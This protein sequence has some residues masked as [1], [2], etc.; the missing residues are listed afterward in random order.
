MKQSSRLSDVLHV[1]LHLAQTD[2][3]LTSEALATAIDTHPVVLRRLMVGLREAG[4]VASEKGHGGGWKMAAPLEGVTLRD[5]H[6]ALGAPALVSLGFR[7]DQPVCLVA[8]V[9]NAS[10]RAS[11]QEAEAVLLN[12]LDNITLAD[13]S[14][15][16]GPR[17]KAHLLSAAPTP[18]PHRLEDHFGQD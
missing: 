11:M 6:L 10:L 17:L 8:Q 1:L 18:T 9:V 3:P 2:V 12:R 7:E 15:Q 4:F 16:F 13:L 14:E 5:V